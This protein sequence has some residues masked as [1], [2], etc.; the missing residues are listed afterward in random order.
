MELSSWGDDKIERM[1]ANY[2]EKGVTEG[3]VVSLAELL[4]AQRRRIKSEIDTVAL[5]KAIV[6]NAKA[7]ADGLTTYKDLWTQFRPG[8]S[9][10]GNKSQQ[11][12]GKALSRVVGY[13]VD[14]RLPIL[15]VLVVQSGS[16]TLD[17]KAVANI[18]N[19]ARDLGVEVGPE[20][21][22]FI[23]RQ[24]ELARAVADDALP[25]DEAGA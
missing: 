24:R 13:C 25:D 7:A 18:V 6:T 23:E 20:P 1:I 5:A 9:W 10:V 8:E 14:H 11:I 12:M 17:P 21:E 4:V 19:D 16:R 15:T 22:K 2:R 3:G